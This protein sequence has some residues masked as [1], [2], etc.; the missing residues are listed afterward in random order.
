MLFFV[1]RLDFLKSHLKGPKYAILKSSFARKS[2]MWWNGRENSGGSWLPE[3]KK[4]NMWHG[5]GNSGGLWPPTSPRSSSKGFPINPHPDH[6]LIN[7]I[8][9]RMTRGALEGWGSGILFTP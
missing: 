1:T 4:A 7:M 5:R 2:Q 6:R 3:E 8:L 9:T